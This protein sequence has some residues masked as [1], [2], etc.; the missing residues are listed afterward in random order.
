MER[1]GLSSS[2]HGGASCRCR[3]PQWQRHRISPFRSLWWHHAFD[4]RLW[5]MEFAPA[6]S[7]NHGLCEYAA[8]CTPCTRSLDRVFIKHDD[9]NIFSMMD[10]IDLKIVLFQNTR[11]GLRSIAFIDHSHS[12][13]IRPRRG[14]RRNAMHLYSLLSQHRVFTRF[15]NVISIERS[16]SG[17]ALCVPFTIWT[18]IQRVSCVEKTNLGITVGRYTTAV[19]K[20]IYI[21]SGTAKQLTT[22]CTIIIR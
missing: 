18:S 3:C 22:R 4:N 1:S 7:T 11:D 20:S 19:H 15:T 2:N 9:R 5:S 6:L 8:R 16:R 21:Y 17:S 14:R 13:D 10:C 12:I